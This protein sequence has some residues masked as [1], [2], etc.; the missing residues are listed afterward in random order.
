[1]QSRY[2]QMQHLSTVIELKHLHF[3]PILIVREINYEYATSGRLFALS[4]I[5][6]E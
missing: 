3:G 1:M 4:V 6:E 2:Y 5:D